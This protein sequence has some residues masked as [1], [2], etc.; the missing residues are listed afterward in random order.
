MGSYEKEQERLHKLMLECMDDEIE[1][2]MIMDDS[3]IEDE[4]Q[5][6][7]EEQILNS[8][9]EQDISDSEKP[10]TDSEELP[11]LQT[12]FF[13]GKDKS[14]QWAKHIP[15]R[16]KTRKENIIKHLPGPKGPMK[17]LKGIF[18]IWNYFFDVEML[19]KIVE[20]TN[21]HITKYKDN[22]TRERNTKETDI[23]EIQALISL[24]YLAGVLKSSRLSVDDLWNDNGTGVEQFRL[25][26]SKYRFQFLLQNLRFDNIDTRAER[27]QVDRLAPV[28]DLFESFVTN[29]KSAYTPFQNVTIDEKLEAFRGR[30][31]FRQYIPSKPNK[32]GL[33]V[34]AMVDSKSYY[35]CNLEVYVGT[36]PDGPYSIDNSPSA[37]VQR[38]V[39]PIRH[40]ARNLTCDN[41]F[42]S[43][44]LV[45]TL[46]SDYTLT[47]LG[48]MR[49]NKREL[50]PEFS[51]PTGRPVGSSMFGFSRDMTIVS[52]MPKR[53]KNVLL[54]SSLHHDDMIDVESQKPQMIIDYNGSKGGVDTLDKMCAAYDCA[55]NTRRWPMVIFYSLLNIAGVN[56]M[57][58][59]YLQNPDIKLP[60]R[61]FLHKL[62]SELAENHLRAR[63][64]Q[65]QIPKTISLRIK[66]ILGIRNPEPEPQPMNIRGRCY[67]CDRKK[68][69]PTRFSCQ[70]CNK[71]MC[72]EHITC[73]CLD[74]YEN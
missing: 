34:F 56:S 67:Y 36:Q 63:A 50:P 72:L 27:K 60:R 9:S 22:Y 53:N 11:S 25:T 64:L 66:E 48:T 20:Y 65:S 41:W 35:T 3:D 70:L 10:D 47:F 1:T 69:R 17:N 43:V 42:T 68:N 58:L 44:P 59:Y 2:E 57:I 46:L 37:V 13:I 71:F 38:L 45:R 14:T 23:A 6:I 62:S 21:Q 74:C 55:R 73:V 54:I 30:C 16:S 12:P 49:K 33:K 7:V 39:E 29:C 5:D 28:R 32:Y 19:G 4:E 24:L 52:Y 18:E 61:K 26:I 51:N 15:S 40:S 31:V 8:G